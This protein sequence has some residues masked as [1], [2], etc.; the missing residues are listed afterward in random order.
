MRFLRSN[1]SVVSTKQMVRTL[2]DVLEYLKKEGT[3]LPTKDDSDLFNIINNFDIRHHN[4]KQKGEYNKEIWYD[5]MFYTFLSSINVL[6]KL[7][8]KK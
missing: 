4:R 2:A 5:W 8:N 6:L 1:G 3:R 7:I